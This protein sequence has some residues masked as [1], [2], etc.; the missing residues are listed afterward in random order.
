MVIFSHVCICGMCLCHVFQCMY[1]WVCAGTWARRPL[2]TLHTEPQSLTVPRVY[3]LARQAIQL[4]LLLLFLSTGITG[5]LHLPEC[6][7]SDLGCHTCER[8]TLPS[9]PTPQPNCK[10]ILLEFHQNFLHWLVF[11][12]T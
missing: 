11:L 4:A 12:S 1:A 6:W 5:E 3:R 2:S 8:N 9:E 7:G 10:V